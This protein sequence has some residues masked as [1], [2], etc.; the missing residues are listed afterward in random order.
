MGVCQHQVQFL[1]SDTKFSRA[2]KSDFGRLGVPNLQIDI[3]KQNA[4]LRIVWIGLQGVLDL[5]EGSRIL[6]AVQILLSV[7][8]V[9][10]LRKSS[11]ENANEI[12]R[13]SSRERVGQYG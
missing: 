4:R 7:R 9:F 5:D 1:A 10:I 2:Q 6:A 3:A 11:I 8:D 12:G 13:E